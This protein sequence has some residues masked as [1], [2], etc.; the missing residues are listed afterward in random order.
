MAPP[1]SSNLGCAH[2]WVKLGQRWLERGLLCSATRATCASRRPSSLFSFFPNLF[3]T[4]KKNLLT[5][6]A[7]RVR[8]VQVE[9][10]ELE[11]QD[12]PEE[13]APGA[14]AAASEDKSAVEG[15]G[16]EEEFHSEEEEEEFGDLPL[17]DEDENIAEPSN[18][19]IRTL[20][21]RA[22]TRTC[23]ATPR[24]GQRTKAT[25][26]RFSPPPV[27]AAVLSRPKQ[28][29]LGRRPLLTSNDPCT[30]QARPLCTSLTP[31]LLCFAWRWFPEQEIQDHIHSIFIPGTFA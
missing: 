18:Q 9:E 29:P 17:P 1:V 4:G 26:P 30:H 24:G 6:R 21:S 10:V 27:Y 5:R 28:P 31:L 3:A 2:N 15:S 11:F 20:R 16:D 7:T 12:A 22:H 13:M 14:P 8:H 19:V 23:L 25:V